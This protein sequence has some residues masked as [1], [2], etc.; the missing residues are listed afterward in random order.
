MIKVNTNVAD[1][2]YCSCTPIPVIVNLPLKDKII[3][4]IPDGI[5]GVR[6]SGDVRNVH[7]AYQSR[8]VAVVRV[9]LEENVNPITVRQ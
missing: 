3:K 1:F 2:H 6:R 5:G 7:S 8:L 9:Q 4:Q